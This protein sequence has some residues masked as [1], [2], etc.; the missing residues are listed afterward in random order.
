MASKGINQAEFRVFGTLKRSGGW[1]VAHCPQ[2]DISTQGRT[3][4][5]AKKNLAQAS[6][7]FLE[8]CIERG[9]LRQALKELGYR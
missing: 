6:E 2:L 9:T 5:E 7:L 4:A 3:R 1:Y 8:S